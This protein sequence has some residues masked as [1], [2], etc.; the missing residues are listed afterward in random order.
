MNGATPKIKVE[1][2]Q[3]CHRTWS[4]LAF[5]W[6]FCVLA[7]ASHVACD[8][9]PKV[10]LHTAKGEVVIPVEIADTP[11]KRAR[12]LM[13][14]RDLAPN[15]GML[16][17]FPKVE[18]LEFWMKNTPLPLDM[19]F[20]DATQRVVGIV[21]RAK[22]FST[23]PRGPGVPAQFVL[24]VHGGFAARHGIAVGQRAEFVRVPAARQ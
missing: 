14:R 17:V 2:T 13:Y 21:E 3:A 12:G 20:F 18:V 10:I 4:A 24:E 23:T 16:F 1:R 19:I 5:S 22:P 8:E 9:Q 15:A 7:S 6:V 11:E